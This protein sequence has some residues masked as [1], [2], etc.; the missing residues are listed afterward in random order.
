MVPAN[1][2]TLER[3]VS[4][5][6]LV[7]SGTYL[8]VGTRI[9]V[10]AAAVHHDPDVFGDD[11]NSFKP[12]RWLDGEHRDIPRM[13]KAFFAVCINDQSSPRSLCLW[14]ENPDL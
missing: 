7:L 14:P 12:E 3:T 1:A 10:S 11:H 2:V 8:P 13:R 6:G 4:T 5:Q 9:G